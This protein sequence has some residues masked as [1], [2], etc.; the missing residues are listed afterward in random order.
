MRVVHVA[1]SIFNSIKLLTLHPENVIAV[2]NSV[3][4]NLIEYFNVNENKIK[5]I[6]NG[7]DDFPVG[8]NNNH[9]REGNENKIKIIMIGR[10]DKIKQQVEL[11]YNT[12]GLLQK[13]IEIYFAG[14]GDTLFLLKETI[15][16]Y[17]QYKILGHIDV[18][19]ELNDY[20]YVCLFSK[21]E[22]LPVSL[23]EGCKFGKPL[24]TNNISAVLEIN[25]HGYNGFV[26]NNWIALVNCINSL[27]LPDSDRYRELSINARQQ[28]LKYFTIEKMLSEYTKYLCSVM[29]H[30]STC[31][32]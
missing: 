17:S 7:I 18:N 32:F 29:R 22:G 26:V 25:K 11:V 8:Y 19:K 15:G 6:F 21:K 14:E 16:Y 5:V 2:S 28:Y 12:R 3:K 30:K 27:P 24:V 23:I 31:G 10:L 13:N 9:R 20:D 1:H 4:L